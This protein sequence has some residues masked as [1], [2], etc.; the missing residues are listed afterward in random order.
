MNDLTSLHEIGAELDPP[1]AQ[2]PDQLRGRVLSEISGQPRRRP[3]GLLGRGLAGL[4]LRGLAMPRLGWRL[5]VGGGLAAA[6]VAGVLVAQTVSIGD[7]TPAKAEAAEILRQAAV[8]ARQQP[9][10]PA[11][12]DQFVYV[13]S[14]TAYQVVM[15]PPQ[16]VGNGAGSNP[17]TQ[18]IEPQERRIWLSVDGTGD[19]LLRQRQQPDGKWEEIG[20]PGCRDGK[21]TPSLPKEKPAKVTV[22]KG[23]ADVQN[24]TPMPAYLGNLPTNAD[25]MYRYLYDHLNG[26]NPRDVQAFITVGDLIRENYVGPQAMAAMFEAAARI[27]GVTVVRDVVDAAGRHGVAVA[28]VWQNTRSE[29]IFDA[30]TYKYLGERTVAVKDADGFHSGEVTGG[31]ARLRIAIV[32]QSGEVPAR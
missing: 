8:T 16:P 25:A 24:C 1:V 6:L 20:L 4:P 31:A 10:L 11:R 26:G 23:E 17:A 7:H 28:Q 27:P 30:K 9:D 2:P 18:R 5:A 29:L 21:Q 14:D 12:P 19:G 32:D 3:A 22:H 13:E 15:A